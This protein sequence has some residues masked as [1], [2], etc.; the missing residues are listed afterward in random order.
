MDKE[1]TREIKKYFGTNEVK[2]NT[3]YQNLGDIATAWN[4]KQ[5]KLANLNPAEKVM[6]TEIN[7]TENS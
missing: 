5:K 3:A 4:Q 6:R 1:I 7:V 2:E